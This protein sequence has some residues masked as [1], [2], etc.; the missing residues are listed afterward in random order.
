MI[1]CISYNLIN[2]YV[3]MMIT[4]IDRYFE[5]EFGIFMSVVVIRLVHTRTYEYVCSYTK[6]S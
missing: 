6:S 1:E 2:L 5:A 3:L 4:R